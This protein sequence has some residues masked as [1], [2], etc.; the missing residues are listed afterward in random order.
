MG[1]ACRGEEQ[2]AGSNPALTVH[3]TG[4]SLVAVHM[5][6]AHAEVSGS[7]QLMQDRTSLA[8]ISFKSAGLL[9]HRAALAQNSGCCAAHKKESRLLALSC[10]AI[11]NT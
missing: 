1:L 2:T 11:R 10:G 7:G 8:A 3:G 4:Q 6:K 9:S 5:T